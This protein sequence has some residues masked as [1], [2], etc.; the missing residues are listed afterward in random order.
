MLSWSAQPSEL[1][2]G[3]P[4]REP[5]GLL[6]C[7]G[8]TV[9]PCACTEDNVVPAWKSLRSPATSSDGRK[10]RLQE[11]GA[12]HRIVG[13]WEQTRLSSCTERFSSGHGSLRCVQHG[14]ALIQTRSFL[15]SCRRRRQQLGTALLLQGEE[16]PRGGQMLLF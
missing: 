8:A 2:G 15:R 10:D 6:F 9:I 5:A 4:A 11:K 14:G 3:R 13:P 7:A 16:I 12:C 1:P